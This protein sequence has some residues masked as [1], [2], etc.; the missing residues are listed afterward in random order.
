MLLQE[1]LQSMILLTKDDKK[2]T[3]DNEFHLPRLKIV[4]MVIFSTSIENKTTEFFLRNAIKKTQE[5]RQFWEK[6][7]LTRV[8]IPSLK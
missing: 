8:S 7:G 4:S 6:N 5:K 2:L 1:R 3:I